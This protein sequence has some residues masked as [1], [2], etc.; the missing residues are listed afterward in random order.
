MK[1]FVSEAEDFT[2]YSPFDGQPT[3]QRYGFCHSPTRTDI[4]A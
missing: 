2:F 1:H 3:L 4:L